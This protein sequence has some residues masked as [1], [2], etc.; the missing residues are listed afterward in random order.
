MRRFALLLGGPLLV[1]EGLRERL[2]GYRLMAADSGGRHALAL[3][4]PLELWLGDFDSSP[5]W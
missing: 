1:G 5:P 3:G 2:K 4:L